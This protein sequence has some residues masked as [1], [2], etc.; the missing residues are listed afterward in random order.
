MNDKIRNAFLGMSITDSYNYLFDSKY[1][2]AKLAYDDIS[3]FFNTYHEKMLSRII[4]LFNRANENKPREIRI[5]NN[6]TSFY[7]ENY[8]KEENRYDARIKFIFDP[9]DIKTAY[10][11]AVMP[12]GNPAISENWLIL[13]SVYDENMEPFST[14]CSNGFITVNP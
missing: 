4:T 9:D 14:L 7:D 11:A 8:N 1:E 6:L 3:D 10:A 12:C 2:S 5:Y 13:A